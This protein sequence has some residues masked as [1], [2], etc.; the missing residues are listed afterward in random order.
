MGAASVVKDGITYI[1]AS[2]FVAALS[3]EEAKAFVEG[4]VV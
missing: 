4:L 2:V 3:F 1:L